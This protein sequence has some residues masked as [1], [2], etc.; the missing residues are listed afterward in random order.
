MLNNAFYFILTKI[1]IAKLV[2]AQMTQS[3]VEYSFVAFGDGNGNYY[4]PSAEATAL[5][6]EVYRAPI[7]IVEHEKDE[8]NHPTN[9]VRIESIIPASIGNFTIREI[10]LIDSNG[11]L[12]G[13][14]K[15]PATYKPSTEQGAAKDLIVRIIV[16]TTNADSITLKVDPS[17]AIASRQYVD[18]KVS[19]MTFDTTDIEQSISDVQKRVETHF[20]EDASTTQKGHVQLSD[21]TSS[22]STT[23]AATANAVKKVNDTLTTHLADFEYQTPTING[24]QIR[25]RK[26][27]DTSRLFFKLDNTLSGNITVSLDNGATSKP[28]LDVDGAQVTSID[29]G[30]AEVVE[31]TTFFTLRS[32][33]ISSAD[34]QALV[35]IVNE[36]ERNESDLR[37]QFIVGVNDVDVFGGI[38]LPIN[39]TWADVLAVVPNINTGNKYA[40]GT[41]ASSST[42]TS[43]VDYTGANKST[44]FLEVTGLDFEPKTVICSIVNNA[45]S[46]NITV[47]K[48]LGTDANGFYLVKR[49][50]GNAAAPSVYRLIGNAVLN[51]GGFKLPAPSSSN[52]RWIAF[53]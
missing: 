25:L 14:G 6:K 38:N 18:Q 49:D 24:A 52:Y 19:E 2:N 30:F 32:R 33:G 27:S 3:K 7:S 37:T 47:T 15:Y 29:K 21:S 39:A 42:T 43:F 46:F 34:L 53:E 50:E 12:V 8:N 23:M 5:R 13:I 17:I 41:V 35:Q 51:N 31:G 11:D 20:D 10:G 44:Y 40:T 36:A 26:Q 48:E 9:R 45:F 4:E 22:T 16:E 28:L 1:G